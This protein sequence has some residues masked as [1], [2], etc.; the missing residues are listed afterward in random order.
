MKKKELLKRLQGN[1]IPYM[2]LKISEDAQ[3]VIVQRGGRIFGPF[4][5]EEGEGL[6]WTSE[7]LND[8]QQ[9]L[10]LLKG[11][12][13]NIGGDRLWLGPEIRYSVSDR[14]RFWETLHTPE[15]IDPGNYMLSISDSR[16]ILKQRVEMER[17]DGDRGGIKLNMSRSIEASGN[18]LRELKDYDRLMENV[19]FCGYRQRICL[20]GEGEA[21]EGWNLL[22][23]YGGGN[24][25]IPMYQAEAG[26]DYY[27]PAG[28][29]ERFLDN[30]ILLKATG[31]N[32]YKV[33]YKAALV[34]GRL[35]Y[36]CKWD[37]DPCL[38]IRSFPN[39]PSGVYEEE[40]PLMPGIHGFSVHVYNDDGN[41][42]GFSEIECTLP[43]ILGNS[44]RNSSDDIISTW[45]FTGAAE[46]LQRIAKVMLGMNDVIF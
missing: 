42:G 11:S 37:E 39:D 24:I 41:S 35:G 9:A 14:T 44:G 18:P 10:E 12:D 17:A 8:E 1:H 31:R 36:S 16:A 22:Q 19:K 5:K 6:F 7:K 33:G 38:L 25:Y 13:W 40:P 2:V 23:V 4:R 46:A 21:V 45:I 34:T 29:Y 26:T 3:I 27:E 43:A 20:D 15:A 28:E 32:R 30:G